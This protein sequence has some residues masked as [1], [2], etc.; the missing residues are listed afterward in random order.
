M[1]LPPRV[2]ADY[3]L[4]LTEQDWLSKRATR[5]AL[6][7]EIAAGQRLHARIDIAALSP[8]GARPKSLAALER[9]AGDC[10]EHLRTRVLPLRDQLGAIERAARRFGGVPAAE[11]ARVARDF[12]QTCAAVGWDQDYETARTA[13]LAGT[14]KTRLMVDDA[15]ARLMRAAKSYEE[16]A[17]RA[18]D[19]QALIR[20]EGHRLSQIV[21]ALPDYRSRFWHKFKMFQSFDIEALKLE[22]SEE[23]DRTKRAAVLAQ[24]MRQT[25]AI[26][27][28]R[29]DQG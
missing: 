5:S 2:L 17:Q 16:G 14:D 25:E 15:S 24:A 10:R 13:I 29:P 1:S 12:A 18:A 28:H 11:V 26:A 20:P 6:D 23:I 7:E 21:S 19:W 4:V 3:P 9:A 27:D 22:G 8:L